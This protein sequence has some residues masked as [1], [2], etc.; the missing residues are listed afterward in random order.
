[1][2]LQ[3]AKKATL[4]LPTPHAGGQDVF[5][6]WSD[7]RPQ[8]QVLV[9]PCGTKLGKSFGS[10]LWL[11]KENWLNPSLYS[12]WIGPT[13][14]KCRIGYRYMKAMLPQIPEVNCVDSKLEIFLPNGSLVK[15]L[16]GKDAETTVEGEAIDRFVIDESGKQKRQLWYSLFTT[17]TQTG[18][19]GIITGTPRG[20]N[21]YYDVFRAAKLGDPFY[22][23]VT[24]P[25][26]NSPFVTAD[27]IANAKRLLPKALFDQYYEA[28]FV[29]SG[30]VFGDISKMF[31]G[32]LRV[33]PGAKFWIHPNAELRKEDTVTGWDIA[34][35][36]DYSVFF[37]VTTSGRLVGYARF[38]RVPYEAQVDRLA[39]YFDK[40]FPESD[41]SLRYDATGVGGA[42]GEMITHKDIDA[43]ITAVIFSNRSKQEMVS[44]TTMA[45]DSGWFKAPRIE[46]I[47]HE[48]A[49][50][51]VNVTKSGLFTYSAP[52]G[53][54]DD[55]VSAG[56]LAITGA[57]Q[58]S[59]AEESEKMIEDLLNGSTIDDNEDDAIRQ[60][61][62]QFGG[63]DSFFD[64]ESEEDEAAFEDFVMDA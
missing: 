38:R 42:V 41:K 57:Y 46:Q 3:G 7:L 29:S 34:K 26:R 27:A 47:E 50:Y 59:I 51:E 48:F 20:F 12:G 33:D 56:M 14:L 37:T 44:R 8:S 61:A 43:A 18:G 24:L 9:A 17:L 45:I 21:W 40:F 62:A 39:V 25:T 11:T 2:F 60:L 63:D 19:K 13:Y 52:D 55:C 10:A 4:S 5:F 36:R 58:S 31:D 54:N 23:W 30:T 16:H 28:L 64:N 15:F 22:S 49:S 1:M 32:E 53:E 6:Y 35:H